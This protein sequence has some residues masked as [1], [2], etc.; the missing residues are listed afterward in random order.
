MQ[1]ALVISAPDVVKVV[2]VPLF[3][4]HED[5]NC[6][7]AVPHSARS[8][9]SLAN[10]NPGINDFNISLKSNTNNPFGFSITAFIIPS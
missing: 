6:V 1:T 3:V 7:P 5:I 9:E 2:Y 8:V 10:N 4:A